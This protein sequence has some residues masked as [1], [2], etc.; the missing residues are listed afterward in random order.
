M[1]DIKTC[2][3]HQK[4][5][6]LEL[7]EDII[8]KQYEQFQIP[9][10]TE[11]WNYIARDVFNDGPP[12]SELYKQRE[13]ED[14]IKITQHLEIAT[15]ITINKGCPLYLVNAAKY[16][17]IGKFSLNFIKENEDSEFIHHENIGA[18]LYALAADDVNWLYVSNLILWHRIAYKMTTEK[19]RKIQKRFG[20]R[21]TSDL[22]LLA[23]IDK[24]SKNEVG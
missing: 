24:D 20:K 7:S 21:F 18:Y 16:H 11:G 23:A 2:I 22:I 13:A 14:Y 6:L 12:L 4:D 5:K 19:K 3:K 9:N 8:W 15:Q 10:P 1:V 17:D